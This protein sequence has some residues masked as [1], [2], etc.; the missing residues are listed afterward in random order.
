[1]E[2]DSSLFAKAVE[3]FV[4]TIVATLTTAMVVWILT[5]MSGYFYEVSCIYIEYWHG[6][7]CIE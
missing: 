4:K 2:K 7:R 1:M 3:T 5:L 6:D